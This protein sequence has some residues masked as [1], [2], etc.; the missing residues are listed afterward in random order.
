MTSSMNEILKEPVCLTNI[1]STRSTSL[2]ANARPTPL[3]LNSTRS[4]SL[5]PNI[6]NARPTLL[7]TNILNTRTASLPNIFSTRTTPLSPNGISTK[8]ISLPIFTRSSSLPSFTV[9]ERR[10]ND[11]SKNSFLNE[12][13][14]RRH[15]RCDPN[16]QNVMTDN[17]IDTGNSI[18]P[19]S[20]IMQRESLPTSPIQNSYP[21]LASMTPLPTSPTTE[22]NNNDNE[23]QFSIFGGIVVTTTKVVQITD[24]KLPEVATKYRSKKRTSKIP[25]PKKVLDVKE[26][27]NNYNT[28]QINN[29]IKQQ[30]K[31]TAKYNLSEQTTKERRKTRIYNNVKQDDITQ[32]KMI[33]NNEH[34]LKLSSFNGVVRRNSSKRSRQLTRSGV[35]IYRKQSKMRQVQQRELVNAPTSNPYYSN[36]PTD[37]E[38]D[39]IPIS[40]RSRWIPVLNDPPKLLHATLV[41]LDQVNKKW[42]TIISAVVSSKPNKTKRKHI[43][44]ISAPKPKRQSQIFRE[45]LLEQ[46]VAMSLNEAI[47]GRNVF[48]TR[49]SSSLL[50]VGPSK[51]PR[52]RFSRKGSNAKIEDRGTRKERRR[53][54]KTE[55]NIK[56]KS[57]KEDNTREQKQINSMAMPRILETD[58]LKK[59]VEEQ[60]RKKA[61]LQHPQPPPRLNMQSTTEFEREVIVRRQELR[62]LSPPLISSLPDQHSIQPEQSND[63]LPPFPT[64][65]ARRHNMSLYSHLPFATHVTSSAVF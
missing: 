37:M 55:K 45:N 7:M 59:K 44:S 12:K 33:I 13:N 62:S 46:S 56:K 53:K 35:T 39:D 18:H 6:F 57:T 41:P 58:E 2:P 49:R 29:N 5:P 30:N 65:L 31:S 16:W 11:D 28:Q 34:K 23:E 4:T 24:S 51:V 27:N 43:E 63:E 26:I 64:H 25:L 14:S 19:D 3:P 50:N 40:N 52:R 61:I 21:S 47:M 9:D 48:A 15:A 38:E 54:E 36:D 60:L 20:I 10:K 8:T 22:I 42:D 1:S 17:Q 32:I